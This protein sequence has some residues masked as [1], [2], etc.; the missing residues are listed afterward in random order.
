VKKRQMIFGLEKKEER[1]LPDNPRRVDGG[2]QE[3]GKRGGEISC[4][5][6]IFGGGGRL[7]V[8]QSI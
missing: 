4:L 1:R 8:W 6:D 3:R 7:T 2:V 5:N